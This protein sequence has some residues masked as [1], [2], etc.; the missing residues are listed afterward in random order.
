MYSNRSQV[1]RLES[2]TEPGKRVWQ[3]FDYE[4]G[5]DRLKRSLL[6]VSGRPG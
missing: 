5:T 4:K 6:D 3:T 1:Q 2:F